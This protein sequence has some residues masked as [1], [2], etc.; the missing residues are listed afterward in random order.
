[1]FSLS[2]SSA[3]LRLYIFCFHFHP[4][5]T[6]RIFSVS[7][8]SV[9]LSGPSAAIISLS[10][11]NLF[12]PSIFYTSAILYPFNTNHPSLYILILCIYIYLY[13]YLLSITFS[14]LSLSL[15]ICISIFLINILVSCPLTHFL[16]LCYLN[17]H[18]FTILLSFSH[19]HSPCLLQGLRLP[20][21]H[22]IPRKT[23]SWR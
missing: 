2:S 7:S 13:I 1:M 14:L 5:K 6:P 16:A 12:L 23:R 18:Y 9:L 20:H 10:L 3:H 15:T 22:Y 21:L 17:L 4:C 11:Q 19:T 8:L